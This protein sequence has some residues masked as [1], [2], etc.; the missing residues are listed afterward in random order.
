VPDERRRRALRLIGIGLAF[1]CI[2]WIVHRFIEQDVARALDQGRHGHALLVSAAWATIAYFPALCL[3]CVAWWLVQG[4]LSAAR[5]PFR[6][7]VSIHATTQF[8]KYLPGNV[9]HFVGRHVLA[10]REGSGD[11]QLLAGTFF[12]SCLLIAAAVVWAGPAI[13]AHLPASWHGLPTTSALHLM[14]TSALLAGLAAIAAIMRKVP[15]LSRRAPVARPWD[16][17]IAWVLYLMFF[18]GMGFC[19]QASLPDDG[20]TLRFTT[21]TAAAAAAWVAGF[22][23]FGAPAGVGVRETVL[24]LLLRE[25][26]PEAD[27]LVGALTFRIATV[28][29]DALLLL[30]GYTMGTR[31]IWTSP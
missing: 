3:L 11:A 4:A 24:V 15:A 7:Y 17:A 29:G 28:S 30:A 14:F 22:V 23:A 16:L 5:P 19:L 20:A 10:R 6:R 12:E 21:V 27:A 31:R 8:A 1:I 26:M 9:G 13:A 2:A 25:H 18:A